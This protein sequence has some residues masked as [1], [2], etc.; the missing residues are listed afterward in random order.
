MDIITSHPLDWPNLIVGFVLG[1]VAAYAAHAYYDRR[2]ETKRAS[3]LRDRYGKLAH[4]Y[5]NYRPDGTATGGSVELSQNQ[6][7]SFKMIGLNADRTVDWESV[8]WMDEQ[9]EN[10]GTARYCHEHGEAY[11]VQLIRYA[12]ESGELHVKGIR[13]S[14][15]PPLV[16]HH[17]W[18]PKQ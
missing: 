13:E 17:I 1:C 7:G 3:R 18:R 12:P 2:Q 11:G 5:A 4:A 16:F 10:H 8:L 6:D 9:F 14:A 15:G